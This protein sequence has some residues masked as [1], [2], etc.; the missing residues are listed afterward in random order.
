MFETPICRLLGL[1]YP[2]FQGGMAYLGTAEL[3]AAVSEAG[4]L[5]IIGSGNCGPDWVRSQIRKVR[6]KTA[7]PFGVNVMLLSPFAAEVMEVVIAEKVPVVTTGAG[8]PGPH[9]PR[10]KEAGIKVIPVV[11]A[12]S[13]AKRVERAGADAVIAEGMESGGHIGELTTMALVPQVVDAVTVAVIAGGGI[14]DGRGFLAALALG[15]Q[16]VQMG[17]RFVCSEECVAHPAYK[18]AICEAGD[19]DTIVTGRRTGHPVRSLRNKFSREYERREEA[20]ESP[21]ELDRLGIGR[22]RAACLDGDV[23]NGT[24]LAGQ[25]AGLISDI[26]PAAEI[27]RRTIREAAEVAG[28]LSF[29]GRSAHAPTAQ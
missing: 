23:D 25:V 5:G 8:N 19:R 13:L 10:L 3:A 27:V 18:R 14:A 15:A 26:L 24:V 9:I 11:A 12:V 17:T 2:I 20:G 6:T 29:L 7:R 28:R 16:G 22:Y 1:D 4:G 21:E